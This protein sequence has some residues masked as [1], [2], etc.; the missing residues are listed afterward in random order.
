MFHVV[1]LQPQI[2]PNTGNIVRLCAALTCSLHLVRPL[3]FRLD[4]PALRRAA[5][6]YR[7]QVAL[8]VHKGFDELLS[9]FRDSNFFFITKHG[10]Q[11]YYEVAFSRGDVLV[12]GSETEGISPEI[13]EAFP[14]QTIRIPMLNPSVR[15][16]NLADSVAIVLSEAM[17]QIAYGSEK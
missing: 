6:D 9:Q 12:F 4:E 15:C 7:D 10:T 17:R 13:L 11:R 8:S 5:L 14:E 3:G 16:L 1:L 2:P